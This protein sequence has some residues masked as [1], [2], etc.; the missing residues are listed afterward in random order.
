MQVTVSQYIDVEVDLDDISAEH[1]AKALVNKKNYQAALDK[2]Q[3]GDGLIK[4][5]DDDTDE[6][7]DLIEAY[8]CHKPIEPL[9]ASIAYSKYGLVC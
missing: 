6:I 2:A 9:L 1:L 5:I 3:H 7:R 4:S 8:R